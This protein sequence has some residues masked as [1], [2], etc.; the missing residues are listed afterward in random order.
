MGDNKNEGN[1][2]RQIMSSAAKLHNKEL[3]RGTLGRSHDLICGVLRSPV[4]VRGPCQVS[5]K[6]ATRNTRLTLHWRGNKGSHTPH[7]LSPG[8]APDSC[9]R[10]SK[11][12]TKQKASAAPCRC[13]TFPLALDSPSRVQ[14]ALC[15]SQY[16]FADSFNTHRNMIRH[17][18]SEIQLRKSPHTDTNN[19]CHNTGPAG[20]C[21][22]ESAWSSCSPVSSCSHMTHFFFLISAFPV[23]WRQA[24]VV[25]D[26]YRY[27]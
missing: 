8:E 6:H 9:V 15:K 23:P 14:Y 22:S 12:K 26:L 4:G 20:D 3:F 18:R 21:T 27:F 16:T 17:T 13:L 2:I 11:T 1:K 7:D 5:H 19:I 25:P 24:V 10:S